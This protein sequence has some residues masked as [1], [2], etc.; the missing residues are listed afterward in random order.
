[1][2]VVIF[3]QGN[4]KDTAIATSTPVEEGIESIAAD[5]IALYRQWD[6]PENCEL[7]EVGID[8]PLPKD[9]ECEIDNADSDI[10]AQLIGPE[11]TIDI[12]TNPK[13]SHCEVAGDN[14]I[15]ELIHEDEYRQI[16][17]EKSTDTDRT[18]KIATK[19]LPQ[20]SFSLVA[21]IE[22]DQVEL[23]QSQ[24]DI[25]SAITIQ[26][27]FTAEL[28]QEC[29]SGNLNATILVPSDWECS[30]GEQMI[31]TD[32]Q[33]NQVLLGTISN[34]NTAITWEQRPIIFCYAP[35]QYGYVNVTT[36]TT[37][38]TPFLVAQSLAVQP[39][40]ELENYTANNFGCNNQ[41][42]IITL[43]KDWS[44]HVGTDGELVAYYQSPTA[45]DPDAMIIIGE[46]T[47]LPA[48]LVGS[49]GVSSDNWLDI[50]D[51][52][53]TATTTSSG[54]LSSLTANVT[55]IPITVLFNRDQYS[56]QWKESLIDVVATIAKRN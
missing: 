39:T 12:T 46:T 16:L 20:T 29:N 56:K 25:F 24:I 10:I 52:R 1:M 11:T 43:D 21:T 54:E 13:I 40:L 2:G 33:G 44:C 27:G 23:S 48:E 9:W 15:V 28:T 51:R 26:T 47:E 5:P 37:N 38:A 35:G 55:D 53:L 8:L 30:G 31:A 41:T 3:S 34:F 7:T 6:L 17:T 14:C 22:T 42:Y 50:G 19:F 49:I 18:T 36:A 45:A 32:S 4:S